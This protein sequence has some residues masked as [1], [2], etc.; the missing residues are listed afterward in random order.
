MI[1]KSPVSCF[2]WYDTWICRISFMIYTGFKLSITLSDQIVPFIK[3][4]YTWVVIQCTWDRFVS[5]LPDSFSACCCIRS[6]KCNFTN[7]FIFNRCDMFLPYVQIKQVIAIHIRQLCIFYVLLFQV[8][9]L[10]FILTKSAIHIIM[11]RPDHQIIAINTECK[12]GIL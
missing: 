3:I 11:P 12:P 2:G 9:A 10:R 5:D 7:R 6:A 4:L 8:I 1:F